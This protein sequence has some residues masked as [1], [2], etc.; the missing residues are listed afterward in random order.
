MEGGVT[1]SFTHPSVL[2]LL[3]HHALTPLASP[4]CQTPPGRSAL[5]C[6]MN[7]PVTS[8]VSWP[9]WPLL[10]SLSHSHSGCS[11]LTPLVKLEIP[12]NEMSL[13]PRCH[14][15]SIALRL[16][17]SL[18]CARLHPYLQVHAVLHFS[19]VSTGGFSFLATSLT[20]S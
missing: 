11:K 2:L 6:N 17:A 20:P 18:L 3:G 8:K 19:A 10:T 5:G 13:L 16:L 9:G 15:Y 1:S 12:P 14:K 4:A 7:H